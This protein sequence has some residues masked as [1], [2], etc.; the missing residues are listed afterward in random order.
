M[1]LAVLAS[2]GG[3]NLQAILDA[4]A[5]GD[6]RATPALVLSDREE[7]GA[8]TRAARHGVPT[9]VLRPS[10]FAGPEAFGEA[11][12]HELVAHQVD[13]VALAGYM[14]HI[15]AGVVAAFRHRML[16]IHPSLLPAFGGKGLYGRRVHE[17]VLAYGVRWTGATVHLVDEEYDTG[18]IVVQEPVPVLPDDTADSLAARVL[19]TEHRLYPAA[20]RLFASGAVRV[21][22]RKVVIAENAGGPES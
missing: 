13:L 7:A 14:R 1:R 3:S 16:N 17:A 22:G 20:L 11:L 10:D 5:S 8:L 9:K 18:P 15:P 6:L 21:E 2:G 19:H 4:I 12:L